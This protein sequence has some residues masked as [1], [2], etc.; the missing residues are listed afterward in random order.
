MSVPGSGARAVLELRGI[1]KRY[2]T[3]TALRD[4]DLTVADAEIVVLIGPSGS[5]KTTLLR[6]VQMLDLIDAGSIVYGDDTR[7]QAARGV[8]MLQRFDATGVAVPS[9]PDPSEVRRTI[10]LVTQ[11]YELWDDR[12]VLGNLILAPMVILREDRN[13]ATGRAEELCRRF[14]LADKI[15]AKAWQLSGGQ[16]QRVAIARALMMKPRCMLFDEIT[17]SL[18]PVLTYEMMGIL[19][20]LKESGMTMLVVTHQ[21]RFGLGLADRVGFMHGGALLQLGPPRELIEHPASDEVRRF[22]AIL[23]SLG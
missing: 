20:D 9:T 1:G 4:V 3:F 14:G 2:G 17:A 6:C 13:A 15:N 23:E 5:G 22:L 18:D 16:R 7:L 12:T 10:G 8:A 21:L 19:R 11:G